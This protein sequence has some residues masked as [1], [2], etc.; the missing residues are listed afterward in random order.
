MRSTKASLSV[1]PWWKCFYQRDQVKS[2][3][4]RCYER[5]EWETQHL[6]EQFKS[7]LLTTLFFY[8]SKSTKFAL[9]HKSTKHHHPS[10]S[11]GKVKKKIWFN[12]TIKLK[13]ILWLICCRHEAHWQRN[14][15]HMQISGRGRTLFLC[16]HLSLLDQ[17]GE[18]SRQYLLTDELLKKKK[19]KLIRKLYSDV[20]E[21]LISITFN[22][23]KHEISILKIWRRCCQLSLFLYKYCTIIHELCFQC[24]LLSVVSAAA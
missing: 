8:L 23:K 3:L 16:L 6:C 5:N 24:S 15:T 22:L 11:E 12:L 2:S 20:V 10:R 7:W 4:E 14:D 1:L 13:T 9:N 18:A 17:H 19:F 21:L